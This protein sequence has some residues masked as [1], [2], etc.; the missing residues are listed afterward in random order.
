MKAPPFFRKIEAS[1]VDQLFVVRT[2][3]RENAL[4]MDELARMGITPKTT[5]DALGSP[6]V[7]FL[8]ETA[9]RIIGFAMAD[10]K[11]GE[12]SAIAVLPENER[13]GLGR[14]LLRLTEE[15]LWSAGHRSIWLWTSC[16]RKTRALR[17][18]TSAGWVET[19]VRNE[20]IYLK[21]DRR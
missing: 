6:V 19:E 5:A 17:F 14:E 10:L 18:Y 21:K 8:C 9:D 7:G 2:S 1:D 13:C 3:V 16:D 20:R 11:T 15:E 4:D 12:F